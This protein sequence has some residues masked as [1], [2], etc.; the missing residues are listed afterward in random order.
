M[1]QRLILPLFLMS[2]VFQQ[3]N[4]FGIP[5]Y[6]MSTMSQERPARLAVLSIENELD[7]PIKTIKDQGYI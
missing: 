4:S 1:T 6:L 3:N 7:E 2:Y 5:A